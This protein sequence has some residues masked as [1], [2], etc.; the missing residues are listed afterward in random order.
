M[1]YYENCDKC[2][3]CFPCPVT[4]GDKSQGAYPITQGFGDIWYCANCFYC[5]DV[6]PDYSP[7]QYAVDLRRTTQQF[8]ERTIDPIKQLRKQGLLFDITKTLDEYRLDIGLPSILKPNVNEIDLLYQNVLD[9]KT[10]SLTIPKGKKDLS[11]FEKDFKKGKIALFLGCLIP[12]RVHDYELSARNLLKKLGIEFL[13]LPFSCCGS[14]MTESQSEEL[15]LTISAYNLALA[16]QYGVKTIITLCG[17]C[18]GNLRRT[19]NILLENS[20]ELEKVN[21]HLSKISKN[22]SGKITIKHFSEFLLDE[23]LTK[24]LQHLLNP[25]KLENLQQISA[26]VQIPCQ[27]IRPEKHSPNSHLETKLL[28]DLMKLTQIKLVK[29]PYELMC[30][31]SSIL[32]YDEQLAYKIAKKRIDSLLKRNVDALIL[33]C[34]NCSMNFS[35]HLSEYSNTRLTTLFF[36]EVLDYAMGT[37]N[38]R[39]DELLRD[40]KMKCN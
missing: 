21:E 15:W 34:G 6:C 8:S 1:Q 26:S 10:A 5:E 25:S 36:T 13:D 23:K 28:T 20:D 24:D 19:N 3:K 29:Y 40:K 30:C 31:G 12:Y 4:S 38:D 16:E 9:E 7:R 39:I 37:T 33:G 18:T 14:I 22:Y 27:V 35:V 17:G 32:A 11:S 2:K